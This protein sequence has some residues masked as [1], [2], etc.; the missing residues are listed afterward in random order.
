MPINIAYSVTEFIKIF[1]GVMTFAYY[2][3]LQGMKNRTIFWMGIFYLISGGMVSFMAFPAFLSLVFYLPFSL[4]V[5]HWSFKGKKWIIPL[6]TLA[7]VLYN[8]YLAYA[9]LIF[10]GIMF[11]V[12]YFK[13]KDF[14]F[15]RLLLD[16]VIFLGLMI[17]GLIMSLGIL[18]PS[19]LFIL[20]DTYRSIGTFDPW[21]VNV[22]GLELELFKPEIYIR[23]LAKMFSEQR[24]IAFYGFMQDYTKEHVSL[25]ITMT[26]LTLMSY[27]YFM[28]DRISNIYKVL[29]P[30][31]LI[32]M[33]FPIFSYVFSERPIS[34]IPVGS[35]SIP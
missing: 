30:I 2:L 8:F 24:P 31:G 27:V 6:Y 19:I 34:P 1:A 21:V 9:A 32:L 15:W 13:R 7:L 35:I 26:G 20:E 25:Y 10:T 11:I 28:K 23:F 5:I 29:I 22:F 14:N 4:L 17:L 18:Y 12:E 3:S 33:L 16:G